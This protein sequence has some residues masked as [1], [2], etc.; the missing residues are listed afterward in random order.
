MIL[1]PTCKEVRYELLNDKQLYLV[2]LEYAYFFLPEY[3]YWFEHNTHVFRA[4]A[5]RA[6]A[7]AYRGHEHH[8]FKT[9]AE[10]VRNHDVVYKHKRVKLTNTMVSDLARTY[11][12]FRPERLRMFDYVRGRGA[13]VSTIEDIIENGHTPE[14]IKKLKEA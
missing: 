6:D 10:T 11:I 4:C 12:I 3:P 8:A 9:V 5:E 7:I 1:H 14:L 13:F 2:V